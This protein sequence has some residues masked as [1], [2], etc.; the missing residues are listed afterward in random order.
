MIGVLSRGIA[1]IQHLSAFLGD[2]VVFL[3]PYFR[4]RVPDAL[5]VWGR[6]PSARVGESY[7]VK[8]SVR[9]LLRLEDGFVRSILPG[10][11]SPSCSMVLD[12]LGIYYDATGP[13]RFEAL[14]FM[15][16]SVKEHVRA[17]RLL[18][19]W[20]DAGISKYNHAPDPVTLPEGD[21]V[22]V[23]DQTE[24]DASV[25]Y[26][27]AKSD[28]FQQMLEAALD[29][30][31]DCKVLVKEHPEVALGRK[32]GYLSQLLGDHKSDRVLRLG[33][34]VHVVPL[35]RQAKAVFVVTSQ[36]GFEALVHGKRV[37][38]FGMPFYAGWG[39]THDKL[40]APSRRRQVSLEQLAFAA[41]VRYARYVRPETGERCEVEDAIEYIG[42]QRRTRQQLPAKLHAVGF[43]RW[44]KPILQDF[45][46]GH[47]LEF[48]RSLRTVP[49]NATIVRWGRNVA[50]SSRTDLSVITAEDGF[51]RSVGLGAKLVRPVSWVFDRSGIYYDATTE[52]DLERI[53]NE[54]TFGDSLMDRATRLR[55][56]IVETGI[57]K[58]N[59]GTGAW[60]RPSNG[61][62]VVLVVGQ[63]EADASLRFGAPG[64]KTNR[65]LLEAVRGEAPDAYIVYKPHPDVMSGLRGDR[66]A[67]LALGLICDELVPDY[68]V[69]QLIAAVDGVHV[70]TSLAGFEALLRGKPVTTHGAPFYA[71]WGLTDDRC[72]LPRRR[73]RLSVD[74]LVAGA[75]I[76]YP[77]YVLRD[78]CKGFV[79]PEDAVAHILS[80][81][82]EPPKQADLLFREW[83]QPLLGF[84]IKIRD[85][86]ANQGA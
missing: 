16:L 26:G 1:R 32:R 42:L 30:Y 65:A 44:K 45:L 29:L 35:I 57:T 10:A 76:S 11:N 36:V 72:E 79:M 20:R 51:L 77:R 73:R 38:T 75:L 37:Y 58:Y 9:R 40:A 69:D 6:R 46:Q 54:T 70:L 48:H 41:L 85:S 33:S 8:N 4:G 3:H 55:E 61:R 62:E 78:A 66:E 50:V 80:W 68:P 24:N 28:S 82:K 56:S 23:V 60:S 18:A 52:S 22:L 12:D 5:A 39:L 15:S 63:V 53:L 67:E 14:A 83:L 17:Q 7:A 34:D 49:L 64:I 74:M 43:S 19:Q 71:G 25:G 86:A 31:P 27:L 47:H 13:S 84:W 21:F 59:V 2:E 81:R